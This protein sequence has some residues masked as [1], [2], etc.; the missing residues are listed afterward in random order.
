MSPKIQ[1]I[2]LFLSAKLRPKT[3]SDQN[4]IVT[5]AFAL[6]C[7]P[8]WHPY[9]YTFVKVNFW[10]NQWFQ[11]IRDLRESA[12]AYIFG[13][14][15]LTKIILTSNQFIYQAPTY[16]SVFSQLCSACSVLGFWAVFGCCRV[17]KALTIKFYCLILFVW[18]WYIL[19]SW[20]KDIFSLRS[21][22]KWLE[23]WKPILA[24]KM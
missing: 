15:G 20:K 9:M 14:V 7:Q 5:I 2:A 12:I 4:K 13:L 24:Q 23:C 10:P 8:F 22:Q 6:S 16:F 21:Y 3:E 17:N 19:L 11:M 18:S 1:A